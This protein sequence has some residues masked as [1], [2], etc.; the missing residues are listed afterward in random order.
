MKVLVSKSCLTLVI[1][2]T[3]ACQ[4]LLS[5][6][7][8]RQKYWSGLPCSPPGDLPDPEI[9]PGSV[10]L[11]AGSLPSE[12]PGKDDVP[13]SVHLNL[14]GIGGTSCECTRLVSWHLIRNPHST[15]ILLKATEFSFPLSDTR[16][17]LIRIVDGID[18][19]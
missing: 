17:L 18:D 2:W 16:G 6:G 1:S 3:A 8:S 7:F 11:Q 10:A 15:G 12:P 5:M 14:H 19:L 9:E 13:I 4:A